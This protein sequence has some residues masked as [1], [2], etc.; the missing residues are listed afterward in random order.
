MVIAMSSKVKLLLSPVLCVA[1]MSAAVEAVIG[2]ALVS[3]FVDTT[4][5]VL[6]ALMTFLN[7]MF[8]LAVVDSFFDT[9]VNFGFVQL[10]TITHEQRWTK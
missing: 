6:F 2:A 10:V 3:L 9:T 4:S 7:V 5:F 1:L 8:L